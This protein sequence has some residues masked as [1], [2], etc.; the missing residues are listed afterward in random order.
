MLEVFSKNRKEGLHDCPTFGIAAP[1]KSSF[2][3]GA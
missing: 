2:P 3:R 1:E